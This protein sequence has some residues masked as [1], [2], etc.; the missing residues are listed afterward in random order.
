MF[1]TDSS[2]WASRDLFEPTMKAILR[3]KAFDTVTSQK[4][5]AFVRV[6]QVMTTKRKRFESYKTLG[7]KTQFNDMDGETNDKDVTPET[8]FLFV[9]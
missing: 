5:I 4:R 1:G 6:Q 8:S 7:I 3:Q 2:T 9:N